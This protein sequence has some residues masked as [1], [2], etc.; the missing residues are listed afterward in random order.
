LTLVVIL[1]IAAM[2][3]LVST[4]FPDEL[5]PEYSPAHRGFRTAVEAGC[6][7]C[8]SLDAPQGAPNPGITAAGSVP[9]LFYER[10]TTAEL[11]QWVENGISDEKMKSESYRKARAAKAL[12]MPAFSSHLDP[13]D[14]EDLTAYL[15]LMQY[16][17]SPQAQAAPPGESPA[18]SSSCFTCH[19][20]LGQGGIE[21][22]GSLKGYI[23]GFFGTDFR[24]LTRNGNR[25][26]LRQWIREGHSRFFWDQGFAGFYPGRYFTGRQAIRMPAYREILSKPEIETLIDYLL[27]IMEI[28]PLSADRILSYRP[29]DW[30]SF[31]DTAKGRNLE[32]SYDIDREN[33]A[34]RGG[35]ILEQ[36]CRECHGEDK[37][38]SR[39]RLDSRDKA[40][41]G[42]DISEFQDVPA[43]V[44][45]KAGESI[46]VRYI[47]AAEE[48]PSEQIYPM[49]PGE[50]EKLSPEQIRVIHDWIDSGFEW[51]PDGSP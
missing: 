10:L 22:P 30:K 27:E 24:A 23:P 48:I 18:R 7:A 46:L 32:R 39:Y 34:V 4:F 35:A 26:D 17:R 45:G 42:G 43:V 40:I 21:N 44:P 15:A 12:K 31:G 20:E 11:R 51:N 9:S 49:P 41:Q 25:E 8:H 33:L 3:I 14:I 37:Q 47:E 38:R 16:S 50:R 1:V 2:A 36:Y 6:F 5:F 29:P 28:G 13:S 19:G